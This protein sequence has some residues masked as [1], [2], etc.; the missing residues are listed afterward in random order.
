MN[1]FTF[2]LRPLAVA[3]VVLASAAA[4]Q[5]ATIDLAGDDGTGYLSM[6]NVKA[7]STQAAAE[8]AA[9]PYFYDGTTYQSIAAVPLS[10]G[11]VYAEEAS[12]T[13]YNKTQTQANFSTVS[14]GTIGYNE[15]TLSGS[16]VETVGA[17]AVTLTIDGAA[18]SPLYSAYNSGG[19]S[20]NFGWDYVIT[21]SNVSGAGLTFSNG[22]LT[23]VDLTA[24]VSVTARFLYDGEYKPWS[25][26]YVGT[27]TISGDQYSFNVDATND[28]SVVVV[29]DPDWGDV[30]V[31]LNDTRLVFNRAG[32]IAAVSAVP[33]PS[34]YA[35]M[36]GGLLAVAAFAR[37]QRNRG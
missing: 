31:D 1:R 36:A 27:L 35:L 2:T 4:A 7:W 21:A 18:F 13:V 17:S 14:A 30:T 37:R 11:S 25:N 34:T 32:S 6:S 22:L 26:A 9:F 33:E 20:G 8:A 28:Q 16:G 15:A 3:G 23:S 19:G 10:A 5:A 24:T 12:H 29:S